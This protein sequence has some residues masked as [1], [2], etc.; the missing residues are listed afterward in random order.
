MS[1]LL[2][3]LALLPGMSNAQMSRAL[4]SADAAALEGGRVLVTLTLSSAAPEPIVFPNE[5]PARVSIDLPQTRLAMA[6][7][8]RKVNLAKVQALSAAENKDRTRLVI[9]LTQM[10][11]YK[12]RVDGNRIFVTIDALPSANAPLSSGV[13]PQNYST[14][15]G[16]VAAISA[17]PAVASITHVD[18]RRGEKGEGRIIVSLD[19]PQAVAN[20]SDEGG[21]VVARFRNVNLADAQVRRL[22][23]LDFATPVKFVDVLKTGSDAQVVIVPVTGG[24]FEQKTTQLGNQ[25]IIEL[26]PLSQTQRDERKKTDPQYTGEKV[27]LS[28]QSIDIRSLLQ[29]IADVAGT[30]MV[31]SDSVT[32]EIAMR[33][34]NVPW[35]QALDIILRTKG[36]GMRQQGNVM[37]VAPLAELAER[38]KIEAEAEKQKVELAPLR[39]ELIQ[40]NYAKVA[41]VAALLK[42]GE[43][44]ILS[45]RG[46]VSI[47]DRTN[48]LLVLETRE[49]INEIRT[50]IARLD[51]PVRQVLIE[52]RIVIANN[53][54]SKELGARFGVSAVRRNGRNGIISTSGSAEANDTSVNDYLS[55]GGFPV[56]PGALNDRFNVNLP[57]ASDSAGKIALALLGKNYL[58]DL[59]LSALQAEGRGE[60]ISTPR[61]ITSNAKQA[62]IEQGVEIPYQEAASSGATSVSFKKAV[63]SLNVTPQITPDDRIIMDLAVNN[64][65]VGQTYTT[66]SG[67]QVPSIDT[68][69]VTTQ[70][71]V[72]NGQTVVLG[73]IYQQENRNSVS[74]IPLLG[75]IPILGAAFRNRTTVNNRDELLVFVTPRILREGLQ[76][77]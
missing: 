76:I 43:N 17:V 56:S 47:D 54:Y 65:S 3:V 41:D 10:V 39:S 2:A 37:I 59:E 18:F 63:L 77:N 25:T 49:K 66:G 57:A 35:D 45:E 48:T 32:G 1:L 69:K 75:D 11:G 44:S 8:Y 74:K 52:S 42:S 31:V 72:E 55:N 38:D 20:V 23:V 53:D 40:V 58:V 21:R 30:N 9:E 14:L 62:S 61:V 50:L 24:D 71:L 33:L 46:R 15:S 6:E 70:V 19:N 34:Q 73:G 60:I 67:G 29:I 68:R 5:S 16:P 4:Q 36:L 12:V 22:D 28:F 27:S 51:I 7:R 64:D 13:P 26:Q